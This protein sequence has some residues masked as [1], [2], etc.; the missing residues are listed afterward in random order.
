MIKYTWKQLNKRINHV[1]LGLKL[2]VKNNPNRPIGEFAELSELI[3]DQFDDDN[4]IGKY[5]PTKE[6]KWS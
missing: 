4:N 1:Q 3:G 2:D 6:Q 5:K